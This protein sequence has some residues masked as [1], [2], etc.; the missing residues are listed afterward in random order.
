MKIKIE[1]TETLKKVV[2][3]E[4]NDSSEALVKVAKLYTDGKVPLGETNLAGFDLR[5]VKERI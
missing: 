5:V 3:I 4:A 1:I 2:E